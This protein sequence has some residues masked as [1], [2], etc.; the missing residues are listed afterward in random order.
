M[1]TLS[2]SLSLSLCFSVSLSLARALSLSLPLSLSFSWHKPQTLTPNPK[3]T[4]GT[5]LPFFDPDASLLFLAGNLPKVRIAYPNASQSPYCVIRSPDFV[6]QSPDL[7]LPVSW[8][9][10][11]TPPSSSS[12]VTPNFS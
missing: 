8:E 12:L 5:L 10:K 6:T 9:S 4:S 11:K 2:L 3:Q 1:G 7:V